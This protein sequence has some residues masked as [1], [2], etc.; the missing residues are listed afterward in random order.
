MS[1]E[2][3]TK[4]HPHFETH[5]GKNGEILV[6][7]QSQGECSVLVEIK[8]ATKAEAEILKTQSANALEK[9]DDFFGGRFAECFSGLHIKIGDD[10]VEGG[11]LALAQDNTILADRQKML[12]SLQESEHLLSE[13]FDPGDR[14]RTMD[15]ELAKQPGSVL[16]YELIHETGHILDETAQGRSAKGLTPHSPTKY[17]RELDDWHN[18]K[19]HEAFAEGFTHKVL[20]QPVSLTMEQAVAEAV[21]IKIANPAEAKS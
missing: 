10:L 2:I 16:I 19:D 12:I 1:A 3:M 18:D 5:H 4:P 20:G 9:L 6:C 14:T 11:A 8:D 15:D 17:G 7:M 13:Y 21:Q